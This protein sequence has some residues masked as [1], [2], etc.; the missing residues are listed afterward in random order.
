MD[1]K[2]AAPRRGR[3]VVFVGG[4]TCRAGPMCPAAG[5]AFFDGARGLR[6]TGRY[7]EP[8]VGDGVLQWS[9]AE[10]MPLGYDV[11]S[12]RQR[13]AG[14]RIPTPVFALARNDSASRCRGSVRPLDKPN[15]MGIIINR[16]GRCDKRSA[17]YGEKSNRA[18]SAHK[19]RHL[20][21]WRFLLLSFCIR[22]EIE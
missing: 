22:T 8:R 10:Q 12:A 19:N 5:Y 17:P 3:R 9:A 4:C 16:R 18:V 7:V 11:P 14:R 20:A 6:P 15:R 1:G 21:E 2:R 13:R